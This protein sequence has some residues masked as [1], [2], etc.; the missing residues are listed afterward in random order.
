MKT[1]GNTILISGGGSGVGM[2]FAHRLHDLGNTVI[3]AGRREKALQQTIAGR[4][5]MAAVQ[6][7]IE[8]DEAV[9]RFTEQ[10]TR[11]LRT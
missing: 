2:A 7:D 9:R 5:K 1:T 11:E 3:V 8:D 4:L 10:V 6:V